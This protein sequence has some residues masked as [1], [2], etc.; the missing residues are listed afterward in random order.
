MKHAV[1][2]CLALISIFTLGSFIGIVGFKYP[3]V[4]ENEPIKN[5]FI[6][7]SWDGNLFVLNDGRTFSFVDHAPI[8]KKAIMAPGSAVQIDE[9]AGGIC[10]ISALHKGWVCGTPWAQ[11]IRIPL[12]K[13]VVYRNKLYLVGEINLISVLPP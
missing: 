12:I 8:S 9:S 7:K 3:V 2:I 4:E 13:Q 10:Q 6:I 5:P 1:V 11:L